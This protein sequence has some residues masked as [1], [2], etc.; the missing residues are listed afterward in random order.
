MAL[1]AKFLSESTVAFFRC[2]GIGRR[3]EDNATIPD[4]RVGAQTT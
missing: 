3:I 2:E 1:M 4:Y